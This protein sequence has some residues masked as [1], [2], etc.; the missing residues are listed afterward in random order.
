[1]YQRQR[2]PL[3]TKIEFTSRDRGSQLSWLHIYPT[4]GVR[5]D[6]KS[7]DRSRRAL[8]NRNGARRARGFKCNGHST[9]GILRELP[10]E[11]QL[12]ILNLRI[13]LES[14]RSD[15][16]RAGGGNPALSKEGV[17]SP[18]QRCAGSTEYRCIPFTSAVC[19]S[20]F[21]RLCSST[22]SIFS[23]QNIWAS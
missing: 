1:M 11:H 7:G 14:K 4:P 17:Q 3:P 15:V 9:G 12:L 18:T 13:D 5:L 10:P 8:S 19:V 22:S 21:R 16:S 2:K 23:R 20:S 6:R